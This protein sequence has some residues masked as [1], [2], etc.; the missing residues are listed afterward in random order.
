MGTNLR[1][2]PSSCIIVY[3][4]PDNSSKYAKFFDIVDGKLQ[5]GT[6]VFSNF[7]EKINSVVLGSREANIIPENLLWMHEA[8]FAFYIPAHTR[9]IK[10]AKDDMTVSGNVMVPHLFFHY[11]NDKIH[12]FRMGKVHMRMNS[13][14]YQAPFPNI[15]RNHLCTGNYEVNIDDS[16][17]VMTKMKRIEDAF[18]ESRFS[19]HYDKKYYDNLLKSLNTNKQ[20]YGKE[21]AYGTISDYLARYRY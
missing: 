17:P 3:V 9:E 10:I 2:T 6:P 4:N 16:S 13:L 14:L 7:F 5:N 11:H 15:S 1:L 8:S 12:V 20:L 21:E 18:F 19:N